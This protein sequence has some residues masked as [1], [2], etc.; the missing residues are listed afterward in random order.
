MAANSLTGTDIA[1]SSLAQ[2]PSALE[3]LAGGTGRSSPNY[4]QPIHALQEDGGYCDPE[5]SAG[6]E[7]PFVNCA[8]VT[9]DLPTR[10]RVLL[11]GTVSSVKESISQSEGGD[12]LC[13]LGSASHRPPPVT[14]TE[15]DGNQGQISMVTVF[16]PLPAGER[17]FGVDCMECAGERAYYTGARISAVALSDR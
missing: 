3:S 6:Q 1:E 16:G 4:S 13:R 2:V 11:I 7:S 8:P 12:G 10:S 14:V 15:A 17:T 9:V 5:A